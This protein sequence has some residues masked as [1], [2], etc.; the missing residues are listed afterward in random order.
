MVQ[1]TAVVWVQPLALE[2]APVAGPA[3]NGW[4]EGER[5]RK[6]IEVAGE[7]R[8]A[9]G[10]AWEVGALLSTPVPHSPPPSINNRCCRPWSGPSR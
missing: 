4:G 7:R 1:V 6:E 2:I 3:K 5:E 10:L 8:R 9:G